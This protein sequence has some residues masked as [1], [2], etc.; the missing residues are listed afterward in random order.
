MGLFSVLIYKRVEPKASLGPLEDFIWFGYINPAYHDCFPI[1]SLPIRFIKSYNTKGRTTQ[2][3]KPKIKSDGKVLLS[4]F[5]FK[6]VQIR[7][8]GRGFLENFR[9]GS[10]VFWS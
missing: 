4:S 2:N 7:R 1:Y 5:R 8:A 3:I 6:E 9:R 10:K